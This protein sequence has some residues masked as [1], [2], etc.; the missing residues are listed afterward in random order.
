MLQLIATLSKK[1]KGFI[2]GWDTFSKRVGSLSQDK[3][4]IE[5][6]VREINEQF[7]KINAV[8]GIEEQ[9]GNK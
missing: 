5:T 2:D 4:K 8:Q 3:E 9:E 6:K 7:G 1:F